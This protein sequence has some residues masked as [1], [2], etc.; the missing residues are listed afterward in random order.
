MMMKKREEKVKY[1]VTFGSDQLGQ[2]QVLVRLPTNVQ[3][4]CRTFKGSFFSIIDSQCVSNQGNVGQVKK[5]ISIVTI[6]DTKNI[7]L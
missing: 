1:K 4:Q 2:F 6:L 3:L 5:K 7:S